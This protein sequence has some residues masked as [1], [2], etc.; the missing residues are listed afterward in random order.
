MLNVHNRRSM[1][2]VVNHTQDIYLEK[3]IYS[4]VNG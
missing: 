2:N 4:F 3:K 1:I